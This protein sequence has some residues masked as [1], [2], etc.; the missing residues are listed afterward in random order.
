MLYILFSGTPRDLLG[1]YFAALKTRSVRGSDAYTQW[2][3]AA[4]ARGA[5]LKLLSAVVR[6]GGGGGAGVELLDNALSFST[7]EITGTHA[8]PSPLSRMRKQ[9]SA[10]NSGLT[11]RRQRHDH[12]LRQPAAA[13]SL[14][15]LKADGRGL[16]ECALQ[17]L[18]PGWL[19]GGV[20]CGGEVG[21]A[22]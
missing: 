15:Q 2:G 7:R 18:S 20:V 10:R 13:I 12:D 21:W 5:L 8:L 17:S 19:V 22:L 3:R 11:F 9:A 14:R 6:A 1:A 4:G 16:A